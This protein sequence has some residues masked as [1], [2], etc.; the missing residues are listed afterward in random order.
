MIMR[1]F[2]VLLFCM[3]VLCSCS[4][5]IK[6]MQ[7]DHDTETKKQEQIESLLQ[8]ESI[9]N[10]PIRKTDFGVKY[11]PNLKKDL[12]IS[13][14]YKNA[15]LKMIVDTISEVSGL[16]I[17]YDESLLDWESDVVVSGSDEM[18]SPAPIQPNNNSKG[19]KKNQP[20]PLD[21]PQG[22]QNEDGIYV[23][24]GISLNFNGKLQ[25]L[26]SLLSEITGYMFIE[27]N[28]TIIV[29]KEDVFNVTVPNYP[30]VIDEI[31][32]NLVSQG[33]Q[34]LSYDKLTS[35]I[36][37]KSSYEG[38][39]R[40]EK[41]FQ[42]VKANASLITM[43]IILM[44][45]NLEQSSNLGVDWTKLA[46]GGGMQKAEQSGLFGNSTSSLSGN[47]NNN[48]D[49][50]D[51]DE[52]DDTSNDSYFE[53]GSIKAPLKIPGAGDLLG[54]FGTS[55]M[56]LI[57]DSADFSLKTLVNLMENS[58][59]TSLMQNVFIE[60]LSGKEG[61]IEVLT[62]TPYISEVTVSSIN[63][64]D[65]QQSATTEEA[66]DGVTMSVLPYYQHATRMLSMHLVVAVDGIEGF[67]TLSTGE[68]SMKRP[69]TSIRKIDTYL[70]MRADQIGLIGGLVYER[71][72]GSAQGLPIDSYLTKTV[73]EDNSKKELVVILKPTVI[74]FTEMN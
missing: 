27:R 3:S 74:V 48:N 30:E 50:D 10:V 35:T 69:V 18:D 51:D 26:F 20:E 14:N 73:A 71:K 47:N 43:R 38:V 13:L 6:D 56:S 31:Q 4:K 67:I 46:F 25:D 19:A 52:D 29:K 42:T 57:W 1:K 64:D 68:I 34:D 59:K 63:E 9:L 60:T 70:R 44:T 54:S 49:D 40:A 58:G 55:G 5:R 62:K 2:L 28:N 53:G 21:I 37:F 72:N 65:T 33:I 15:S 41:Y 16:S 39:K 66:S 7:I 22:M 45:V 36:T 8:K 23:S 24:G 61:K 11:L 32:T 17:I 12:P